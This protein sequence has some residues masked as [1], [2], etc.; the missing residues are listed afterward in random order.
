MFNSAIITQLL[1]H[2]GKSKKEFLTT[3][4][5]PESKRSISY[6]DKVGDI[7][8]SLAE[9]IADFF[10]VPIDCLG[11]NPHMNSGVAIGNNNS[12]GNFSM[13][14]NLLVE[15]QYLQK[16]VAAKDE[17]IASNK[18][19]LQSKDEV[20]ANLKKRIDELIATKVGK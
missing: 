19:L 10:G 20:I 13:N 4:F 3:V 9:K 14:S 16:V 12:V 17:T 5:N 11:T 18:L 1:S 6:F 8:F 2:S 7:S 15:N